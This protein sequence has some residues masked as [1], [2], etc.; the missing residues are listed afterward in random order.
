MTMLDLLDPLIGPG[1]KGFASPPAL[2]AANR[3]G[4]LARTGWDQFPIALLKRRRG[5]QPD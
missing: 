1:F 5:T 3:Q 4:R 2:R